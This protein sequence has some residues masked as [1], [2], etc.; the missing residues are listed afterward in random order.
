VSLRALGMRQKSG[1]ALK[2][3][4]KGGAGRSFVSPFWRIGNRPIGADRKLEQTR[5]L[6]RLNYY[7]ED[8]CDTSGCAVVALRR[9][10][11]ERRANFRGTVK[12]DSKARPKRFLHR[13]ERGEV[14]GT[15]N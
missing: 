8:V 3:H 10:P 5:L 2:A 1:S 15:K 9:F 14:S 12:L 13:G 4:K 6:P 7:E 11:G